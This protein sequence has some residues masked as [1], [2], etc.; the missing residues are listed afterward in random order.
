MQRTSDSDVITTVD[1]EFI[2]EVHGN[3][4]DEGRRDSKTMG[5][6]AMTTPVILLFDLCSPKGNPV[7]RRPV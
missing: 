1:V 7:P 3:I 6:K 5:A 4:H 2:P